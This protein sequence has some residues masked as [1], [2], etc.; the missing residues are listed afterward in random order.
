MISMFHQNRRSCSSPVTRQPKSSRRRAMPKCHVCG[1]ILMNRVSSGMWSL[2]ST[3]SVA[4]LFA[5]N[6][7]K[8]RRKAVSLKSLFTKRTL[9]QSP[10]RGAGRLRMP[11]HHQWLCC[12]GRF[13]ITVEKKLSFSSC[14]NWK[15]KDELCKK[16]LEGR[17][18][19]FASGLRAN[20]GRRFE[21]ENT[22]E[23]NKEKGKSTVIT[24]E[25]DMSSV[26]ASRPHTLA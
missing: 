1:R 7:C 18:G 24:K 9:E 8:A 5:W 26:R 2:F 10:L 3:T 4:S 20:R 14:S 11:K 19:Y 15:T 16:V 13:R 17:K 23:A 12:V 21:K 22:S 25:V 6:I